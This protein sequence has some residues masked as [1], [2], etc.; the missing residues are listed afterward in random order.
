M[1]EMIFFLVAIVL[2]FS[3]ILLFFTVFQSAKIKQMATEIRREKTIAMLESIA[4]MPEFSCRQGF[5]IDEQKVLAFLDKSKEYEDFW[6]KLK[7]ALIKIERVYPS[8]NNV[9]CNKQSFPN[10][11]RY[12][13]YDSRKNYEAYATY[14]PL[15][16]IYN[17]GG[18]AMEK[19][20]IA[21]LIVGFEIPE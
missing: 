12:I 5:C 15:C 2:L 3:L 16:Y 4:N 18:F 21:E 19:C 13:V 8:V 10:C 14:L 1:Q 9:D 17:E 11:K 6:K 7:I 20:D